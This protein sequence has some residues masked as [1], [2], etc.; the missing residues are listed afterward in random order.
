MANPGRPHWEACKW[1]TRYLKG[2]AGKGLLYTRA[3]SHSEYLVGFVD[4]DYAANLDK[5]RSLT[6]YIFTFFGNVI[7][8]KSNLQSVVA[9]S[10]TEAEYIALSEAVKE[11]MWLKGSI[12]EMINGECNVKIHCDG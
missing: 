9:L 6:G 12:S 8:W 5:R 7:S 10:S 11:A 3:A 2:T 4:S 1:I